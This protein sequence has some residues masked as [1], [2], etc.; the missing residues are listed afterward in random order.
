MFEFSKTVRVSQADQELAYG[1]AEAL[2]EIKQS[3]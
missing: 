2:E 3:S 1:L